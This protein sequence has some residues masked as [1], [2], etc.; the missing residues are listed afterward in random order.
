MRGHVSIV[1]SVVALWLSST[2]A[3]A[4]DEPK[5]G[6]TM[7]YPS[8]IGVLWQLTDRVAIRPEVTATRGSSE[9][10]STDPIL[11]TAGTST[12]SDNWQV[13]VGLSGLFYLTRDGGL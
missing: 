7:G 11:G 8:A 2:A 13:A 5:I 3:Q 6:L 10:L 4:Q 1:L 12:P 9:G